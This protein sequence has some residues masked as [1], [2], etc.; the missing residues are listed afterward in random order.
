VLGP[1]LAPLVT[2]G[3]PVRLVVVPN[4]FFGGTTAVTGLITGADVSEA[5]RQEP[6]GHRYLLPD[7][8]LSDDRFLDGATVDELPRPVEVVPADGRSLALAL[9]LP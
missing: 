7:V 4:R 6:A 5:L 2:E 9:G 8:C 1:L 3:A